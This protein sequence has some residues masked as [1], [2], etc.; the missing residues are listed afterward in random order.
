MVWWLPSA[1]GVKSK[2]CGMV[3][4]SYAKVM[5]ASC[6]RAEAI[7]ASIL[8]FLVIYKKGRF[9]VYFQ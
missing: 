5:F 4:S 7:A 9:I 1:P 6:A 3:T 8:I 2:P